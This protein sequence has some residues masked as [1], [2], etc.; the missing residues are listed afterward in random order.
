MH[1]FISKKLSLALLLC[2]YCTALSITLA[3]NYALA[4]PRLGPVYD[5][6]LGFRAPPPVSGEILLIETDEVIEPPDIFTVFMTLSEMGAADLLVEAP[7]LGTG[8]GMAETGREFSYRIN[9]E[10]NLLER[11]IRS[12]FEGIRLGLVSPVESPA[13]VDNLVELAERGRE[14]LNAAI[15]RQDEAGSVRA[16]QAAAVFGR[17][18]TAADLR[19]APPADIPWYSLPR[20][21][22]DGVLRRIAPVTEHGAE[23]IV[24]RALKPRWEESVV[25][26][27]KT[28]L[29][30]ANRYQGQ[31]E[32]VER[33]FPLDR[34]GN[35]LIE[36]QLFDK[37]AFGK[38]LLGR[39]QPEGFRRLT[40]NH[41]RNYD[42]TGRI[43]ARLLKD[44]ESAGLY[45]VTIPEHIP[46]I[47]YDYAETLKE[48]LLQAPDADKR[49]AWID[50]RAEYIA[51]L[52][53]FLY[54]PA[55]MTL[56]NG[57]EVLIATEG[58]DEGGVAR[59][60]GMRDALIRAFVVMRE[61]HRDLVELRATLAQ[62][63]DSSFCIMGP[64]PSAAGMAAGRMAASGL[65]TPEASALLANALLTGHCIKPGQSLYIIL[66]SLIVSFLVL[67]CIHAFRPLAL[68]ALG[69]AAGLFC[70]AV[71]GLVFILSS[72]WIDPF[73][74]MAALWGGTLVL[75]ISRFC[76]GYDRMLRFR[77][78][79]T[80]AVNGKM[81]KTLVKACRPPLSETQCALAVIIAVKNPGMPAREDQETPLEAARIAAEFRREF[82]R[83]FKQQGALV[84]GFEHD[85]ALA[86]FGSPPQRICRETVT[87]PV[88]KALPCIEE[89]LRNPLSAGWRFGVESGECAFS[90]S[91]ETGYTA[92]GHPVTRARIFASLALRYHVRVVIGETARKSSGLTLRKLASLSNE[93]CYELPV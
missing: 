1:G 93:S 72:Y 34:D 56:V 42:Q 40:L 58:L 33:R 45:A 89:M 77:L 15:I 32:G 24:Y 27:G 31:E 83:I 21:D 68:L 73:I 90:W 8:S 60:Q 50:A 4:G 49:A 17:V 41:F 54:G 10:F 81:L 9:D 25:E 66:A 75:A 80:G 36:K 20:P 64:A 44:A 82:S 92:N 67:A 7:L 59:L 16:A 86:C 70:G 38:P 13:Y 30:L 91:D 28:G 47:L 76:I 55:E 48:E 88:A 62:A 63:I 84:L 78:A 61:R 11:N 43:L 65:G 69:L 53:D 26:G 74:P 3:L 19:S 79:F 6:L 46:L 18:I 52:D 22:R 51:A 5:A 23:H 85:V 37:Q 14:R 12:L 57:Y 35:I 87:H 29:F 39:H 2:S 71:F